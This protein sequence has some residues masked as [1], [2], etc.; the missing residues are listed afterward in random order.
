MVGLAILASLSK[1]V[2]VF[3]ALALPALYFLAIVLPN[4][5]HKRR[6][7]LAAGAAGMVLAMAAGAWV[8]KTGDWVGIRERLNGPVGSYF[9]GQ[10]I[11]FWRY[12]GLAVCPLPGI[13]N[14]DHAVTYR[15]YSATDADVLTSVVALIVVVLAPAVY[16]IQKR[17][18]AGFLLLLIPVAL[19]PYFVMTSAEAMVEYRVYLP[20]AAVC[21]LAGILAERL[22]DR[23][24]TAGIVLLVT[25][26][27]VLALGTA[28]RNRAC[29]PN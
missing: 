5:I 25:L 18:A 26:V 17:S 7:M 28:I 16:L 23:A 27:M 14:A 4:S 3:Y 1:Q 13:L 15:S 8:A 10:M 21:G 20:L 22:L 6:L 9:W 24:G 19:L 12:M 11:V 2:G 29:A